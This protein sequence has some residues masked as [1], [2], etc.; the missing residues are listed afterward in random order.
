MVLAAKVNAISERDLLCCGQV[1]SWN[2]FN[3]HQRRN[4]Y[5]I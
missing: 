4:A 3:D 5:D 1:V 2:E